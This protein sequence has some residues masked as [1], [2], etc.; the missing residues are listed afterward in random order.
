[1]SLLPTPIRRIQV[2][3]DDLAEANT[4]SIQL[5]HGDNS[6]DLVKSTAVKSFVAIRGSI[7]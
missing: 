3:D 1:M 5:A 7:L 6:R 4:M 2:T